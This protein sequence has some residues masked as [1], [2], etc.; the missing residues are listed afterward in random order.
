MLKAQKQSEKDWHTIV[1]TEERC[2][3]AGLLYKWDVGGEEEAIVVIS[4]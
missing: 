4:N 2:S 3:S 1:E